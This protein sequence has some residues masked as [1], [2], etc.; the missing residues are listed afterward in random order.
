MEGGSTS[1]ILNPPA[2]DEIE[3]EGICFNWVGEG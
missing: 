1:E 2:G 3:G